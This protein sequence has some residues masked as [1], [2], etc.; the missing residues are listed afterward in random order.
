MRPLKDRNN[1]GYV[2]NENVEEQIQDGDHQGNEISSLYSNAL[3][4]PST[5]SRPQLL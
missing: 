2:E 3:R 1:S 5:K 4:V